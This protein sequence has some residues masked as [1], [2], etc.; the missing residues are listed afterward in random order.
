MTAT[1]EVGT[2]RE[3]TVRD[4]PHLIDGDFRPAR[5]GGWID[6]VNPAT[7]RVWARI[8][9]GG[10]EDVD[11]AV[12]A[13]EAA[14]PAWRARRPAERAA[15]LRDWAASIRAHADE[16]WRTDATDNGRASTEAHPAVLGRGPAGG[17]PRRPGRD[18]HR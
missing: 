2:R 11:D 13:A 18:D 12:R 4:F 3:A 8:P 1:S 6:S 9:D 14:G 16:L 7:G 5:A 10:A 15:I 17:V